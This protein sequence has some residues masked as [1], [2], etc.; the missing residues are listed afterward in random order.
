MIETKVEEKK[1]LKALIE[2]L[3]VQI[4]RTHNIEKEHKKNQERLD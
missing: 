3:K 4:K 1:M 2:D